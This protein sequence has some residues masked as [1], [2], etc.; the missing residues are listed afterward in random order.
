[1]EHRTALQRALH[2]QPVRWQWVARRNAAANLPTD[3]GLVRLAARDVGRVTALLARSLPG[4]RDVH[5]DRSVRRPRWLEGPLA[6]KRPGRLQTRPTIGLDAD[7]AEG[8]AIA[9]ASREAGR[10]LRAAA[11]GSLPERLG[12]PAL[13]AEGF[14]G[15]GV[16]VGIFD[17]G[18][19]A[20]QPH[21]K[22]I[23]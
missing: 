10:E 6:S 23:R 19:R 21:I 2:R 20:N 3:F 11:G 14:R 18:I 12:A 17:T 9:N 16:K 13:W 4:F 1:M 15:E 5:P 22:N 7:V 8:Y